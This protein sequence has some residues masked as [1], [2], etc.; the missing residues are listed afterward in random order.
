[1]NTPTPPRL[2]SAIRA[3]FA[4]L[5]RKEGFAGSGRRFYKCSGPWIQIITVQGS[6]YGGSFAVNFGIHFASA[7]DLVGNQPDPKKMT[8]AHREFRRRLSASS[9]DMWWNHEAD[10][11]SMLSAVESAASMYS[12]LAPQYFE[13]ACAALSAITPAALASGTYDLQGFGS[14]TVRLALALARIRKLEGRA[15]EARGFAAYGVKHA[16]SAGSLM[17]ELQALAAT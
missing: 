6:R 8:E 10:Q 9:S 5:L 13:L 2:E 16:G 1:M 14:T 7:P 11:A 12:R 17:T 3:A 4:P 15:D